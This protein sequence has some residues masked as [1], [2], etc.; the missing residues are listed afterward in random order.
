MITFTKSCVCA[1]NRVKL[2]LLGV[3]VAFKERFRIIH[4]KQQIIG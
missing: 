4:L 2:Q 3:D 1:D